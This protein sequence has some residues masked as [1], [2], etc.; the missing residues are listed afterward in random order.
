MGRLTSLDLD[1]LYY[2]GH[3]TS[4]QRLIDIA[5]THAHTVLKTVVR[6]NFST[7]HL[8]NF[9]AQTGAVKDKLTNQG[10]KDWS[11]WSR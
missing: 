8:I 11:T 5:T 3:H 6:E 10:Y 1:L 2:V 4:N 9:D 7:Y